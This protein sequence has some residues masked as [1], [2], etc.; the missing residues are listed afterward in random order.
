MTENIK[1]AYVYMLGDI[2]NI[3]WDGFPYLE[4]F[5]SQFDYKGKVIPK[6]FVPPE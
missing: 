3:Y 4:G 6:W 2:I 5:L 1:A